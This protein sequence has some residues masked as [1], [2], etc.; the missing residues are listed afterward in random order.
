MSKLL[1]ELEIDVEAVKWDADSSVGVGRHY[2][3]EAENAAESGEGDAETKYLAAAT[4]FRRAACHYL[5]LDEPGEAASL[6]YRAATAYYRGGNAYAYLLAGLGNGFAGLE[7]GEK[8][9]LS[10]RSYFDRFGRG[11]ANDNAVNLAASDADPFPPR[12]TANSIYAALDLVRQSDYRAERR[13]AESLT[14]PQAERFEPKR[15]RGLGTLGLPLDAYL[16]LA[17][18]TVRIPPESKVRIRDDRF[19]SVYEEAPQALAPFLTAYSDALTRA[20][21]NQYHWQRLAMP[22]HPAEPDILSP[23]VMLRQPLETIE[24]SLDE[25]LESLPM[26]NESRGVLRELTDM[27]PGPFNASR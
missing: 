1:D 17:Q 18:F 25:A 10:S 20:Q 14:I 5:T 12:V 23:L 15:S 7:N 21:R 27:L 8:E 24:F 2:V 22:F 11:D 16:N 3:S 6:F 13:R 19:D 26:T 4:A 9:F